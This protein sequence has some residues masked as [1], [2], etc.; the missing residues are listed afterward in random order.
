[1][2][3]LLI[4][5]AAIAM[6]STSAMAQRIQAKVVDMQESYTSVVKQV[7]VESCN[8]VEVPIYETRNVGGGQASTGDALAGA[9]IGGVIGNQFGKGSGKDAATVLGAIVGADMANKKGS[10]RQETVIV[11]YRQ[12]QQCTTTYQQQQVK[13]RGQNIV[14]VRSSDGQQFEFNT[15]GW[16]AK[17]TIVFLDVSLS[18]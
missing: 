10:T 17:G 11:G 14:T 4:A 5:T 3:T 9:I 12:Q 18:N 2:K 13:Q 16:Y 15:N 8:V 7:P 1:M 6:M